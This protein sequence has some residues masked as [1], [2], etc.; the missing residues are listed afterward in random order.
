MNTGSFLRDTALIVGLTFSVGSVLNRLR[1]GNGSRA[2][3]ILTLPHQE[4]DTAPT[5]QEPEKHENGGTMT[6]ANQFPGDEDFAQERRATNGL[7]DFEASSDEIHPDLVKLMQM[8]E[9]EQMAT[10]D[11]ARSLVLYWKEMVEGGV[12]GQLA[13]ALLRE[14]QQAELNRRLNLDVHQLRY[15]NE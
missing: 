8:R 13:A 11:F 12:P 10:R 14:F 15:E 1:G 4:T 9:Q 2:P 5:T 6:T 3:I 7:T